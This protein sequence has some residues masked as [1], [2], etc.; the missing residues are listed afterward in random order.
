MELR[1]R[2]PAAGLL[3]LLVVLAAVAAGTAGTPAAYAA[4]RPLVQTRGFHQS[5]ATC[6]FWKGGAHRRSRISP[7][8]PYISAC[9]SR[10]G[11]APDGL[12]NDLLGDRPLA[13]GRERT[14]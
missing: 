13:I 8:D 11:W 6:R 12:P 4:G 5:L 3:L 9:L 2:R 1:F 14:P 10:R 7:T